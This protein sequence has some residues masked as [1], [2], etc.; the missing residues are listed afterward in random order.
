MSGEPKELVEGVRSESRLE[1]VSKFEKDGNSGSLA[2][3]KLDAIKGCWLSNIKE[4]CHWSVIC[5]R[6][7]SRSKS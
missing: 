7:G 4:S 1:R 6:I 5:P 3:R 2:P